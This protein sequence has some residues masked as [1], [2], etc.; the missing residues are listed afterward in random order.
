MTKQDILEMNK[1]RNIMDALAKHPELWDKEISDHLRNSKRKENLE[2][3]G[4]ADF[5]YRP[6]KK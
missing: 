1:S 6:L 2:R 5:L 4:D 3:F